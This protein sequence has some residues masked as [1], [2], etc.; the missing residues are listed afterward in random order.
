MH[1]VI[2][3][4]ITNAIKGGYLAVI[5]GDGFVKPKVRLASLI[6]GTITDAEIINCVDSHTLTFCV[7]KGEFQAYSVTVESNGVISEPYK[8]NVPQIK[9]IQGECIFFNEE[10]RIFGHAFVD[11]DRYKEREGDKI[12]GYGRFLDNHGVTVIICDSKGNVKYASVTRAS[13]YEISAIVPEGL[14][15]GECT[16]TV[17]GCYGGVSESTKAYIKSRANYPKETFNV[18]NFGARAI[19][20]TDVF[21]RD[22]HDSSEGFQKALDAAEENGGGTVF[23]PNGRY[24][25]KSGLRIPRFT[26]LVGESAKRVWLELP[27]GMTGDDGW[28]TREEGEKIQVFI[29]GI[30]DFTIESI[31]ILAVYSPVVIGA[32]VIEGAPRLGD[33]KFNRIP[34]Y[35]NLIDQ[36]K[37]ADNIVIKNCNIVHEPTFLV[38][39][40]RDKKELFFVDEYDNTSKKD[41]ELNG[42]MHSVLNVWAAIAIKGCNIKIIDNQIQ[43]A[44]S[45]VN[46]MGVQNSIIS[47]NL[48]FAGDLGNCLGLF[49]TSYNPN[50]SWSRAAKNVII[51]ENTFDI[52]TNLNRGIMWIMQE[53]ANYYMARNIIKPFYWSADAEGFCFH[54][55]GDHWRVKTLGGNKSLLIDK[56]SFA[57]SYNYVNCNKYIDADGS[58]KKSVLKGYYCTVVK[59]TGIGQTRII[60]DNTDAQIMLESS[61]DCDLDESSVVSISTY[62]KFQNTL[63][64][65]NEVNELGRGIYHW[66]SAFNSIVDGNVLTKNSGVLM[67]DLSLHYDTTENWQFAG[68]FFNQIINNKLT[69]PRGFC[70]NYG[71]IGV[72]GGAVANSTVS[73]IIRGNVAEDDSIITACPLKKAE[74]DLNYKGIVIEN[75]MSKNCVIGIK[76]DENVSVTLKENEFE[77][78]DTQ[79]IGKGNYTISV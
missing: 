10:F 18:C 39:R 55:W 59:G 53:H 74:D 68:H 52:A 62:D 66:G 50:D 79:V 54:T 40:K 47:G 64:I 42:N 30:G 16:V 49:S 78:V 34:C 9:W 46:L 7:P 43:G 14:E 4:N 56:K 60:E 41:M 31:N 17:Y 25:F 70:S 2:I 38:Q 48:L 20:I 26:K 45:A 37:D 22:F 6:D 51:E 13:C 1:K 8:M 23:V 36:T 75:N 57:K 28:G 35:C 69:M 76:L 61:W 73:M 5:V 21:Y 77:N 24:C 32:P 72:S 63:I 71:V 15:E 44:G 19:E 12:S 27:K 33:D 58:M 3:R 65:D 67:E 29:G 11:I